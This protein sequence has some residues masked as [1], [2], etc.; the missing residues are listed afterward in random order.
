MQT[1]HRV[2]EIHGRNLAEDLNTR[3]KLLSF[4]QAVMLIL[5]A[6]GQVCLCVSVCLCG[7][8]VMSVWRR[9]PRAFQ[10]LSTFAQAI[11]A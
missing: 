11:W 8:C 2:N 1:H 3:V 4:A 7:L 9:C 5:V 10:C 6:V